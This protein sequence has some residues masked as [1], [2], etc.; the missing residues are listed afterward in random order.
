[1]PTHTTG[2][3][4]LGPHQL[5]LDFTQ[6]APGA[7]DANTAPAPAVTAL[8]TVDVP[9]EA[10][11]N[12]KEKNA[13]LRA[14]YTATKAR[15]DAANQ[16]GDMSA[17]R[18]AQYDLDAIGNDFYALNK[19]LALSAARRFN[20]GGDTGADYAGAAT[21]GLWE[22]FLRWDPTKGA[23]FSTFSRQYISGRIQ[24]T[25]RQVEFNHLTQQE[26]NLRTAVRRAQTLLSTEL[27]RTPTHA[28]I[29]TAAGC[30]VDKVEKTLTNP[31]RSLDSSI[32]DGNGTFMDL[33]AD[34][35]SAGEPSLEGIDGIDEALDEL[36]DLELWV[37]TARSDMLGGDAPSLVEVADTIG[38]GRE[39]ARRA[40]T[41]GWMRVAASRYALENASV[42]TDLQLQEYTGKDAA[43]VVKYRTSGFEDLKTRYRRILGALRQA[44][45]PLDRNA[46]Q[47]RLDRFGE[48]FLTATAALALELG[49]RHADEGGPIGADSAAWEIFRAFLTWDE[50][51]G[52]AFGT[53]ARR[54]L[55][56]T[57]G[58]PSAPTTGEGTEPVDITSTWTWIRRRIL[59]PA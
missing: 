39:I 13:I 56:G 1:M 51:S 27:G 8:A 14:R 44:S 54:E 32:G 7:P 6:D 45:T 43:H 42:A 36:S 17:T 23:Q 24:R 52:T 22:A 37:V 55:A 59:A 30:A 4:T 11:T 16:A 2:T 50:Q 19:G 26:F 5:T 48:E 21:L 47:A 38:I 53:H 46:A 10:G 35:T 40:E 9:A 20:T 58:R 57:L 33:I 15:L 31:N 25:V 12:W 18:Q 29:A 3:D 41:R 49:A 28:E 34:M